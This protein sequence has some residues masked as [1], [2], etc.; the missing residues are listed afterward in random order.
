MK[1]F[2]FTCPDCGG[3]IVHE[4]VNGILELKSFTHMDAY[5]NIVEYTDTELYYDNSDHA[6]FECAGCGKVLDFYEEDL[7]RN[8]FT[9]VIDDTNAK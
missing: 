7:F 8:Y 1:L 2:K 6:E 5:S 3:H 4:V 9:E